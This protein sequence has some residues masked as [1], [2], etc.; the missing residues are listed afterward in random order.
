M[1][2]N[3]FEKLLLFIN[4]S[5]LIFQLM[6]M[7]SIPSFFEF[8]LMN[9]FVPAVVLINIGFFLF[10]LLRTK[11]VFLLFMVAFLIGYAEWG[12]LYQFPR[13]LVHASPNTIKVMTYNVRLF[14]RYDWI[15]NED[16]PKRIQ[17]FC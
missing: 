8:S 5:L 14:N 3:F 6:L 4:A 2:L 13:T 1:K 11:W 15:R 17:Y 16:I 7:G 12:L 9:L 10:W